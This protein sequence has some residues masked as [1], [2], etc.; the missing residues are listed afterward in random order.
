MIF[1]IKQTQTNF[2]MEWIA[3]VGDLDVVCIRAP[4]VKGEFFA[5]FEGKNYSQ[6]L[7]FNPSDTSFGTKLKDR[8]SF[9]LYENEEYIGYMVGNTRKERKGFMPFVGYPYYEYKYRETQ[10][11][12]YEVG[13][14][15]RGVYL[16]IYEGDEL[17]AVV[18]KKLTVIDYKD[19]YTCYM[20]DSKHYKEVVPFVIYY[21]TLCYN[22][23]MERSVR[24]KKTDIV[25]TFQKDLI[26]KYDESYI[27]RVIAQDSV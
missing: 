19:E 4:F 17:I 27:P 5:E 16:C 24:S 26:A 7:V 22:D 1:V 23:I 14:G 15:H 3:Q 21:D 12:G 10:I 2:N 9:R 8:F 18:D 20:L 13:F 11:F 6:R 25:N